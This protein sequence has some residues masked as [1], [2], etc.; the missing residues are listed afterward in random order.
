M[1]PR[2]EFRTDVTNPNKTK[3]NRVGDI[4]KWL[5]ASNRTQAEATMP[6]QT[7]KL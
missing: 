6:Y 3:G 5:R 7:L 1:K 2:M 4:A